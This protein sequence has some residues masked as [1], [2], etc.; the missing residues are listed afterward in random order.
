M[1]TQRISSLE[2]KVSKL[3]A[4]LQRSRLEIAELRGGMKRIP[5][6][7]ETLGMILTALALVVGAIVFASKFFT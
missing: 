7:L 4:D 1:L 6:P 3:A 2:A 5:S